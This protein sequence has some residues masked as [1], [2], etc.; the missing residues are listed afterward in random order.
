[1]PTLILPP[2]YTPDSIAVRGA[3]VEAGWHVER[4]AS[5]RIPPDKSLHQPAL[6]GESLFGAVVADQVSLALYEPPFA[7][8]AEL[9]FEYVSRDIRFCDLAEAGKV[10]HTAFIK[11][12]DDKCFPAKVYPDGASLPSL[13]I[14][15]DTTPVL[16]SEP[17]EWNIDFRFFVLNGEISLA[18]R[19]L[20]FLAGRFPSCW[21]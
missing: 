18:P 2:R 16:I 19:S 7:W 1:M 20:P 5:W 6:Y 11:P 4:L 10:A 9:P 3:A 17:V 8:L 21:R 13:E 15:P 14:L 12:A